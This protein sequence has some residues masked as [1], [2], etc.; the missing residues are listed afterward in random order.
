MALGR[1]TEPC[2]GWRTRPPESNIRSRRADLE[3]R[4]PSDHHWGVNSIAVGTGITDRTCAD[5]SPLSTVQSANGDGRIHTVITVKAVAF[6]PELATHEARHLDGPA[7]S[8]AQN[9]SICAPRSWINSKSS[10]APARRSGHPCI[11]ALMKNIA[12]EPV[13]LDA[14]QWPRSP[15]RIVA[16]P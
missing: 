4:P 15:L 10:F 2:V 11:S 1:T 3:V 14:P 16:G 7:N 6:P 13:F 8:A 12:A 9:R 5:C